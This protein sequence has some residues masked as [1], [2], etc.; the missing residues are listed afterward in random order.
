MYQWKLRNKEN[1]MSTELA[2]T[3]GDDLN[4]LIVR[5]EYA[6]EAVDMAQARTFHPILK[7]YPSSSNEVKN[8]NIPMNHYGYKPEKDKLE[9]LG[10]EVVVVPLTWRYS[11]TQFVMNPKDGK[12]KFHAF[13]DKKSPDYVRIE[14]LSK[15]KDEATRKGN[16]CGFDFLVWVPIVGRFMRVQLLNATNFKIQPKLNAWLGQSVVLGSR[17][18]D[19]GSYVWQG[20]IA[21]LYQGEPLAPVNKPEAKAFIEEFMSVKEESNDVTDDEAGGT[22]V[23]ADQAATRG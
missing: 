11:A 7:L 5:P 2:T 21:S 12:Y 20:M 9:S 23:P 13:Y 22:T 18:I 3:G 15:S 14:Q 19:N 1:Q 6:D 17:R 4:D 10:R 16:S 8:E